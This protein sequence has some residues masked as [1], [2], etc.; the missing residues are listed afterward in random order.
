KPQT[1]EHLVK[2]LMQKLDKRGKGILLMHDIHKRT[3]KAV[4]MLLAE[5]KAKGY[6]IVHMTA[7][8]PA[9]TVAAYDAAI[10]KDTKGLPQAGAERPLESV[11]HTVGEPAPAETAPV[12]DAASEPPTPA[13]APTAP[14]TGTMPES[15]GTNAAIDSA[16][17]SAPSS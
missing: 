12:T 1:A 15:S 13:A 6:K 3:A 4:P 11:V 14:A 8:A 5:L 9:T 17:T 16:G 2:S 7:K 10:E